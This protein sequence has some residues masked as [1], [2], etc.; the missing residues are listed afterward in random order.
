MI[1]LSL[2]P[3]DVPQNILHPDYTRNERVIDGAVHA[4]GV[5]MT[6][7][8]VV[9][10]LSRVSE[11]GNTRVVVAA[12]IYSAGLFATFGL[13][14]AYNLTFSPRWKEAIRRYDHVAIFMMIAGTYTPFALIGIEG[15]MGN[16]L[17]ALVWIVAIAGM[18][19]KFIWPRR[20]ERTAVIMYLVLGWIG[21][22]L[23]GLLIAALPTSTLVLM[24]A[25]AVLYS[26]G[27]AFHVWE[28]LPYH[29]AAW[30]GLVLAAACCHFVAVL[31]TLAG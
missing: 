31:N 4:L 14:A 21:L 26:A 17:F 28:N 10:L 3:T 15:A 6:V 16:A 20:F 27:V 23:V 29:N 12:A 8:A 7:A 22:P 1:G 19:L 5:A 24:G 18:S 25:G 13:S 9:V 2:S 30:H 11:T